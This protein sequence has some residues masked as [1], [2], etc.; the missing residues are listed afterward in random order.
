MCNERRLL[1]IFSI[2]WAN[3]Y[4][5]T[6]II[7]WVRGILIVSSSIVRVFT[8][9]PPAVVLETPVVDDDYFHAKKKP[10]LDDRDETRLS[11]KIEKQCRVLKNNPQGPA[12]S[13]RTNKSLVF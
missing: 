3:P 6:T 4:L 9:R 5:G 7:N 13:R 11:I 1:S 2:L 10:C 12:N 8:R